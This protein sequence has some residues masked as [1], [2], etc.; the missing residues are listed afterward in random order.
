MA[1]SMEAKVTAATPPSSGRLGPMLSRV[2]L[3][4]CCVVLAIGTC[5][6][7]LPALSL[8]PLAI[9]AAEGVGSAVLAV[10]EGAVVEAHKGSGKSGDEDHA[11]E[12]EMEREDRCEQ[13]QMDA[14]GVI[15]LHKGAG[16]AP[17]YRELQ[18][19][20]ALDRPQWSATV[21]KDTNTGG[22][23]PAINFLRMDFTPPLGALPD[24]GSDYVA[25]TL[26]ETEPSAAQDRLAAMTLNFGKPGGSFKWNG[27]QYVYALA[28]RLPC[29]PPPP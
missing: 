22:W 5:G 2:P 4:F 23:R 18:L 27:Q 12:S 26:I 25:Y 17:E 15:E 7:F 3:A 9:S 10:T 14:P 29:F 24:A 1:A 20:G 11:G 16:G 21:D 13:L 19:G 6:C 8:A 28:H